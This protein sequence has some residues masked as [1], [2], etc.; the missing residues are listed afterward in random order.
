MATGI[1]KWYNDAKGFG[2]AI[3]SETK[4]LVL[5]KKEN[6][7]NNPTVVFEFETIS[8]DT[9]PGD[10]G[11]VAL[12]ILTTR[13]QDMNFYDHELKTLNGEYY[14]FS[15][16]AGRVILVVNTASHCGLTPDYKNLEDAYQTF[17]DQG[18]VVLGFPSGNFAKQEFDTN[19]E[20]ATFC[21]TQYNV[22]FPMFEKSNVVP[23]DKEH[24]ERFIETPDRPVNSIFKMLGEITGEL[25]FWNFHKYLINRNGTQVISL[26]PETNVMSEET[27]ALI[28]KM[29][30]E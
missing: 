4:S 15:K 27:Q 7:K 3:D 9:E 20:I 10:Q 22:T 16:Y 5:L 8:Y 25:P 23:V 14:H 1:V 24:P 18:L 21:E 11:P 17:K 13:K 2:F 29:L 19:E 12:N 30:E 28:K 26:D 6:I